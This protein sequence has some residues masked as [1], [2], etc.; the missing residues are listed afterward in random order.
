MAN[1]DLCDDSI[2][3]NQCA[4]GFLIDA[5]GKICQP[6]VCA[7]NQVFLHGQCVCA[8]GYYLSGS[9]CALCTQKNCATCNVGSC[10]T[11]VDGYVIQ[12]GSCAS[13]IQNCK[14]CTTTASCSV[15]F[16]GFFY[17]SS[18]LTCTQTGYPILSYT[19]ISNTAILCSVGCVSCT[20][21][22][23]CASCGPGFSLRTTYC[24][25]C[26]ANC[27]TCYPNIPSS[28]LSC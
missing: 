21:A 5:T 14:T 11:C 20:S 22:S 9:T 2:T 19:I 8:L 7:V 1:C 6:I 24:V 12:S 26:E 16:K 23:T 15:C 18:S 13:C 10:L 17:D 28:C 27:N 3:C 25:P 4:I